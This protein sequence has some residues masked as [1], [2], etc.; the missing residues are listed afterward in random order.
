MFRKP[1]VADIYLK[2]LSRGLDRTLVPLF[3][4]DTPVTVGT[5][6]H[7]ED[8]R[9]VKRGELSQLPGAPMPAIESSAAAD[10][11]FSSEN[12]VSL[13]P[14]GTVTTPLGQ[15][16]AKA[17]LGFSR[18]RSV[19]VSF[20]G[21]TED[22]VESADILDATLWRLYLE[23]A[24]GAQDVVIWS[25]RRAR[26]GTIVV[27]RKGGIK[28]DVSTDLSAVAGVITV[29]NLGV[30]V[31]IEGGDHAGYQLVGQDLSVFVRAKGLTDA[32]VQEVR[33]F[34][35]GPSTT[36]S[37]LAQLEGVHVPGVSAE[38]VIADVD[39]SVAED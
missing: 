4:P 6:G 34:Q 26:S 21:L 35:Q 38:S 19:L 37:A 32:K 17:Q 14:G 3:P 12:S 39:F 27:A 18:D 2:E 13:T 24:L 30:G 10:W 8:G 22:R 1:T 31:N 28:L 11:S 23:G 29:A 9:F 5:V 36:E 16:L 33:G 25:S 20:V 15:Q 7:F